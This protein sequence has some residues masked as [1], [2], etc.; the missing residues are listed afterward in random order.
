MRHHHSP[1][2]AIAAAI[3][4]AIIM[5]LTGCRTAK[6]GIGTDTIDNATMSLSRRAR[7]VA[8]ANQPWTQLN[9]PVKVSVKAPQKL[10]IS[11]RIYMRR[12]HDIYITLRVIG[13][14]VAN[15]Y[16]N[17]DSIFA[18]DKIHKYYI[19]EPIKSIF[20]G[21]SL[22]IGDIQDAL[23]GRPFIN[24]CGTLTADLLDMVTISD[25]TDNPGTE[26]HTRSDADTWTITPRTK[27]NGK[28]AYHFTFNKTDNN[29]TSLT[30]DTGSKTYGCT[31]SDPAD[32]DGSHFMQS[33]AIAAKVGNTAIN[34]TITFDINKAKAEVP[35]NALWRQPSSYKRIN[36]RALI[37]SLSDQ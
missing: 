31:Y 18:T 7:I 32:I 4:I 9:M 19:A 26:A 37:R 8:D 15:M 1:L 25:N 11:G 36:P 22:T 20:A 23:M 3:A 10:S 24:N 13:M 6:T 5:A 16:I 28:I 21:A 14:E 2:H 12:N 34:A 30:F 17:S 27:I 29:L 35:A 33:I